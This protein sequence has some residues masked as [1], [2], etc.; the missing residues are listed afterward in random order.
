MSI[1]PEIFRKVLGQFATGVTIVTTRHGE[2]IHGLTVNAFCSVSLEPPLV[3]VCVDQKAH[4]HHLIAQ[5]GNFA[6]NILNI[7]QEVLSQRFADNTLSAAERFAGVHFRTEVTG[8]P[9]LEVSLGWLDCSLVAAHPGG[10][11]TIFVGK[12]MA[13]DSSSNNS[14]LLYY[15]SQY[16]KSAPVTLNSKP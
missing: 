11:H 2:T 10:D 1:N 4:G 16:Q 7:S 13:L 15:Q 3:L 14:P 8:A 5:G 6:V 12:V 9:I